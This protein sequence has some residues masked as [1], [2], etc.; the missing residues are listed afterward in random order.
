MILVFQPNDFV[1]YKIKISYI[2]MILTINNYVNIC[3]DITGMVLKW[4]VRIFPCSL[5]TSHCI[6]LEIFKALIDAL[7]IRKSSES[8]SPILIRVYPRKRGWPDQPHS[9]SNLSN[10]HSPSNSSF[11][12]K[13]SSENLRKSSDFGYHQSPTKNLGTL[14]RKMS[15]T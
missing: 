10:S 4:P 12:S 15:R 2:D 11:F 7:A 8:I 9:N 6:I 14:R 13:N 1:F 5:Q 3:F